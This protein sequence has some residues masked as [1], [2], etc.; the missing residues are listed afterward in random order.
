MKV[1]KRQ[2]RIIIERIGGGRRYSEIPAHPREDLGKNITDVDFPIVVG[3]EG[4]SEIAYNQDELDDILDMIAGSPGSKTDIP[5]SLESLSNM[6]P[7]SIPAG[8]GIERY[9]EGT[10][11]ITTRQLRRI[12]REAI[13]DDQDFVTVSDEEFAATSAAAYDRMAKGYASDNPESIDDALRYTPTTVSQELMDR[14]IAIDRSDRQDHLLDIVDAIEAGEPDWTL[15][16]LRNN[17]EDAE[18]EQQKEFD[19]LGHAAGRPWEH[20]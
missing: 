15:G 4:Q 8:R 19:E 10:M 13:S 2:L 11:K 17:L 18:A 9:V 1:T 6:E 14:I 20:N 5:Y 12:I 3:Y 7:E 16:L